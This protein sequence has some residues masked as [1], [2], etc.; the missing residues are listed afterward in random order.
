VGHC[1]GVGGVGCW[2]IVGVDGG[3][4]WVLVTGHVAALLL[5][6]LRAVSVVLLSCNHRLS[7]LYIVLCRHQVLSS[8]CC[9]VSSAV[10]D[11]MSCHR[12]LLVGWVRLVGLRWGCSPM[13]EKNNE[14][15]IV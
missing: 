4:W 8:M 11:I 10:V 5:L 13:D 2:A 14:S 7:L 6:S 12:R 15:V 3:C 1:S 9:V